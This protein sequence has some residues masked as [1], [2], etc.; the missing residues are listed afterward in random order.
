MSHVLDDLDFFTECIDKG[1]W[2]MIWKQN[3][4][5]LFEHRPEW[6][7]HFPKELWD[8][9][10]WYA[11]VKTLPELAAECPFELK[12]EKFKK[13]EDDFAWESA[14][15]NEKVRYVINH[16][17]YYERLCQEE[18]LAIFD[19]IQI[20]DENPELAENFDWTDIQ[21]W[22]MTH[23][24]R[25]EVGFYWSFLLNANPQFAVY[26][27]CL[28][29]LYSDAYSAILR[30]KP[31]LLDGIE[32]KWQDFSSCDLLK[33]LT[34]CPQY[35]D[36]CDWSRLDKNDLQNILQTHPDL[37][38]LADFSCFTADIWTDVLLK[39][40][41]HIISCPKDMLPALKWGKLLCE[42]SHLYEYFPK[43]E[44]VWWDDIAWLDSD[45]LKDCPWSKLSGFVLMNILRMY[46]EYIDKVPLK[47]LDGWNWSELLIVHPHLAQH[48]H[49]G[50]LK[51]KDWVNLILKRR[52]FTKMCPW[53]KLT[54]N[55]WVELIYSF[56][57]YF[58][59]C[60]KT[61]L[62]KQEWI[63]LMLYHPHLGKHCPYWNTFN[64]QQW[65]AVLKYH[66]DHAWRCPQR[67]RPKLAEEWFWKAADQWHIENDQ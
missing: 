48:C 42:H 44:Y 45:Y 39:K 20:F 7:K 37:I 54:G 52:G 29:E 33:L 55:D 50:K 6:I 11:A 18:E 16:P 57:G 21:K 59:K 2:F 46:P 35:A 4:A 27:P 36:K 51:G 3:W 5:A 40:P 23:N 67:M 17:E 53:D 56:P 62:K 61:K 10:H 47:K 30:Y 60:P 9:E 13:K 22:S 19:R 28:Q 31:E 34:E 58:K 8:K 32:I 14:N 24:D 1:Q 49:W 41:E 15:K 43:S 12:E 38:E 26:C 25:G 66:G 64:E 65:Y 63:R